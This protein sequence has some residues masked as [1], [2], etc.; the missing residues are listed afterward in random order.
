MIYDNQGGSGC[1]QKTIEVDG[2]YGNLCTPTKLGY[3]FIGW[4]DKKTNGNKVNE[5]TILTE[6]NNQTIYAYYEK[7]EYTINFNTNGGSVCDNKTILMDEEYG[8]LCTPS[9]KGYT[10]LGWYVDGEEYD[11]SNP[12]ESDLIIIA[13][14]EENE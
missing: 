9:K 14:W 1:S 8:E 12:V 5:N 11:F 6:D 3:T 2:K 4:Y 7:N 13:E 10:F